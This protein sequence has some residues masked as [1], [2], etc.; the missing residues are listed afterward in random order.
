MQ[1][2]ADRIRSS[3]LEVLQKSAFMVH[4]WSTED[5]RPV[6][7]RSDESRLSSLSWGKVGRKRGQKSED[8][9]F[10]RKDPASV[11]FTWS[12]Q[13][14]NRPEGFFFISSSL[15]IR[16]VIVTRKVRSIMSS[17]QRPQPNPGQSEG[18]ME[19][20]SMSARFFPTWESGTTK[21]LFLSGNQFK[22]H[23][24]SF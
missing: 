21:Y 20:C 1:D 6:G 10:H 14:G 9:C 16:Q 5:I 12:V 3:E 23:H 7:N 8:V 22:M 18:Q 24:L 4:M 11:F 15:G 19:L 13:P 2:C 17:L